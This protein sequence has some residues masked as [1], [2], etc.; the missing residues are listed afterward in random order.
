MSKSYINHWKKHGDCFTYG[1]ATVHGVISC[2]EVLSS[3]VSHSAGQH[4]NR[5]IHTMVFI[6][7]NLLC[8]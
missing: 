4:S 5:H 2:H 1:D 6:S 8:G 7:K 3:G